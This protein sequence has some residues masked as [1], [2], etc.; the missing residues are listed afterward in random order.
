MI[1]GTWKGQIGQMAAR[2]SARSWSAP[3]LSHPYPKRGVSIAL[4]C[5]L[6]VWLGPPRILRRSAG[7]LAC[8]I[9]DSLVCFRAALPDR[10][11]IPVRTTALKFLLVTVLRLPHDPDVRLKKFPV[12]II[13]LWRLH[14]VRKSPKVLP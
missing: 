3:V 5:N 2:G 10:Q 14:P 9:A 12:R 11:R 8:C 7:S 13:V 6:G 4:H 1:A